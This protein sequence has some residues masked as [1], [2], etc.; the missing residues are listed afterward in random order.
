VIAIKQKLKKENTDLSNSMLKKAEKE[1][2][3]LKKTMLLNA[4]EHSE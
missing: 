4:G 2:E 1:K 3:E